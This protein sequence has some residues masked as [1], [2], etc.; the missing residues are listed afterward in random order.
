MNAAIAPELAHALADEL[1]ALTTRLSDLAFELG[2]DP[3][4]LRR[5]MEAL[6][7]IDFITQ[8]QLTVADVLRGEASPD[9]IGL[10]EVA[11]RLRAAVA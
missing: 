2:S 1:V 11:G 5:H 9:A 7:A 10:E 8:V 6:Q 3:E 4:V